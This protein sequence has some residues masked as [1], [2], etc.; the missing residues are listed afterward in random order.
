MDSLMCL[1]SLDYHY[2]KI[3]STFPYMI[4]CWYDAKDEANAVVCSLV[5]IF[6]LFVVLFS[7]TLPMP[8]TNT[9]VYSHDY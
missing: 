3:I 9:Y 2:N 5:F 4:L 7:V 8:L 1:T 6:S